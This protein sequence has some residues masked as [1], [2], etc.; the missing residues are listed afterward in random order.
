M[1]IKR[2]LWNRTNRDTFPSWSCPK[3]H[4]GVLVQD[5]NRKIDLEH[6]WS[7]DAHSHE[8]WEPDWI[9]GVFAIP[10]Q[11]QSSDCREFVIVSGEAFMDFDF[12]ET[13]RGPQPCYV[14]AYRPK[15]F[16]SA[17]AIIQVPEN[18]PEEIKAILREAFGLY[19]SDPSVCLNKLRNC[20]EAILDDKR[21]PKSS[22]KSGKRTP[23]KLHHRIER[24]GSTQRDIADTLMALK[25]LGNI[26]SHATKNDLSDDDIL[27]AFDIVE[28]ALDEIYLQNQKKLRRKIRRINNSKGRA[29]S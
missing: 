5:N 16:T 23:L 14:P 25:W 10:L 27:D 4:S 1:T 15:F 6:G 11:C 29:R 26:G 13:P 3:C 22:S 7:A 2:T 17:P 21:V 19:W 28:H 8:A 9:E 18:V 20:V 12:E 24:Y